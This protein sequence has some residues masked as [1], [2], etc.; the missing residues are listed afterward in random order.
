MK[1]IFQVITILII[2][3]I[4]FWNKIYAAGAE[5]SPYSLKTGY[6][7]YKERVKNICEQYKTKKE[8]LKIED[9]F[10]EITESY[11]LDEIKN[12]HIKNMNNIYKCALLWVQ[13]K[14]LLLIKDDLIKKNPTLLENIW[15]KID[16]KISKL[17][18]T[19]STLKCNNSKDKSSII[20]LN[21]LQQSTYE[22][23]KYVTYLEYLKEYN[24]KL[25]AIMW[26][27]KD[28][29][30][31]AEVLFTQN[32]HMN[33]LDNEIEHTYKVFPMAFHALTEYENNISIHFLLELIKDDYISLREKLHEALNPINQVVYKISN[34]MRK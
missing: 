34:A 1:K 29:Y 13:K 20:K 23:C 21:V 19:S 27:E 3:F 18:M 16:S 30:S 12:K 28:K 4:N 15:P 7:L 33:E 26:K 22:T 17:E 14:S 8:L 25:V 32:E 9:S 6:S 11:D 2:I 10:D 31:I 5:T 24:D